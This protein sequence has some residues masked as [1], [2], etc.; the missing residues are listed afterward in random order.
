MDHKAANI[1]IGDEGKLVVADFGES[2]DHEPTTVSLQKLIDGTATWRDP[3][4]SEQTL[5][6]LKKVT[7]TFDAYEARIQAQFD[8][9]DKLVAGLKTDTKLSAAGQVKAIK[10]VREECNFIVA[11]LRKTQAQQA[12]LPDAPRA[13]SVNLKVSGHA[14]DAW[15]CG[16][17]LC[18]IYCGTTPFEV[19]NNKPATMAN[20]IAFIHMSDA[21]RA[22]ALFASTGQSIPPDIQKIILG[23]MSASPGERTATLATALD[24]GIFGKLSADA[25]AEARNEIARLSH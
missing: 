7:A 6:E 15:G 2:D 19:R 12:K 18:E 14:A 16:M 10:T 21:D 9:R 24:Q 8:A 25:D 11:E 4:L 17:M 3:L 22:K 5:A 23:L 1:F 20:Q 13:E